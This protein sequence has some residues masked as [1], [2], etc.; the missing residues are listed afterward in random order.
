MHGS[1]DVI[2][3][4]IYGIF[5]AYSS[6][7]LY[8]FDWLTS[9]YHYI[10]LHILVFNVNDFIKL[11][12]IR[13]SYGYPIMNFKCSMRVIC[14][15]STLHMIF[16]IFPISIFFRDIW[17]ISFSR[18]GHTDLPGIMFSHVLL[19]SSRFYPSNSVKYLVVRIDKFL[20]WFDQ[21]NGIAV[22]LNRA[23]ILLLKI[24]NYFKLKTLRN[25]YFAIFDSHLTYSCIVWSQNINTVN[26][27]IIFQKKALQIMDFKDQLFHSS[28]ILS[29][30]N[31]LKF[32]DKTTLENILFVNKSIKRKVPPI[33]YDFIILN[34]KP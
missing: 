1:T 7:Q 28:P 30:N 10:N 4:I 24:E 11:E 33:F 16:I 3:V 12:I 31:I 26:R 27:L 6:P 15:W 18:S 20:H 13:V 2:H 5:L 8:V 23:N 25:I 14:S 17:C 29:E 34:W 19:V 9:F 21:V 22:K 32:G